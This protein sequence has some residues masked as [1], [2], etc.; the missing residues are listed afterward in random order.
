MWATPKLIFS[1]LSALLTQRACQLIFTKCLSLLH[2]NQFKNCTCFMRPMCASDSWYLRKNKSKYLKILT[3]CVNLESRKTV[4]RLALLVQG[5]SKALGGTPGT[6]EIDVWCT[7]W[8][9][10]HTYGQ[11]HRGASDKWQVSRPCCGPKARSVHAPEQQVPS[12]QLRLGRMH[13]MGTNFCPRHR[14]TVWVLQE[15]AAAGQRQVRGTSLTCSS[16]KDKHRWHGGSQ[17]LL[18]STTN[19]WAA[20]GFVSSEFFCCLNKDFPIRHV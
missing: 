4:L 11:E 1:I 20:Y 9:G 12:P 15:S 6:Q 2:L 14:A 19:S 5:T 8:E 17:Q 10:Y 16:A 18:S 7:A 13:R 3:N